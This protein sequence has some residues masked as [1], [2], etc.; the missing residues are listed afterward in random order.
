MYICHGYC[1]I[2][3][4]T[5]NNKPKR[6]KTYI[7]YKGSQ[8]NLLPMIYC[9]FFGSRG[10]LENMIPDVNVMFCGFLSFVH[11]FVCPSL[12]YII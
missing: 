9:K 3:D 2:L 5:N 8:S 7:S 10:P 6:F 12:T 1:E 11:C 4:N